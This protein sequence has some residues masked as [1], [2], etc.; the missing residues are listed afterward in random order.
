MQGM[1]LY[2]MLL[3]IGTVIAAYIAPREYTVRGS[4]KEAANRLYL[5]VLFFMLFIPSALRL[6]TGNDYYTYIEH[7]HDIR[8]GHYVVT[9]PGFNLLVRF[10]YK[11]LGGEYFLVI[12]AVFAFFTVLF[13]LKGIYLQSRDVAVSFFLFLALGLYF[14]SYNSVRYYLALAMG[15]YALYFVQ[16]REWGKFIIIIL[17]AALFHKTALVMLLLYPAS[18]IPW[19]KWFAVPLTILGIS[20]LVF[21]SAYMKLFVWLYPSYV[22][23]EEYLNGDYFSIVNIARCLAVIALY[24]I[25]FQFEKKELEKRKETALYL[26]MNILA[27]I[28]YSCF[29]F[30]PFVSRIGYYLN[31]SQILMIPAL[32]CC[33]KDKKKTIL[34]AAVI[35]A[36]ILYF[37]AFL[38]K[39]DNMYIKILPYTTWLSV[40][41]GMI[42]VF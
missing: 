31:V 20:G 17:A 32:L 16:K 33:F 23:E 38:F 15:L 6:Y 19:K 18:Y 7:F 27:L 25:A 34:T 22:N 28:M 4:R 36:G 40:P 39:A 30:V 8:C 35:L 5:L 13:F 26:K 9:E 41:D 12:F 2:T 37:T 1:M 24:I 29:S 14:Q 10:I 3:A 11:A 21:K 42:P